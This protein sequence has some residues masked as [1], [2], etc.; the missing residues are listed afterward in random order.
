M[1]WP[2]KALLAIDWS[3][4]SC[5]HPPW[6]CFKESVRI[7][8]FEVR[9]WRRRPFV[10]AG[11]TSVDPTGKLTR[12]CWFKISKTTSPF[13]STSRTPTMPWNMPTTSNSTNA[14]L[15]C[16]SSISQV[17][18]TIRLKFL[19]V[20]FCSSGSTVWLQRCTSSSR[21]AVCRCLAINQSAKPSR[22]SKPWTAWTTIPF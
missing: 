6:A 21:R 1:H 3:S 7:R 10:F 20:G 19:C 22:S 8:S 17:R 16:C 13:T 5:N 14:S 18:V 15:N 11:S 12:I 2:R 4:Q 9:P